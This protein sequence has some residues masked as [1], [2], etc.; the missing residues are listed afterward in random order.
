MSVVS[1]YIGDDMSSN[2]QSTTQQEP[3]DQ[4]VKLAKGTLNADIFEHF[5]PAINVQK[6]PEGQLTTEQVELFNSPDNKARFGIYSESAYSYTFT[7]PFGKNE[8]MHF[9]AGSVTLTSS[10]GSVT[11]INTGDSIMLPATW[12]GTWE[13]QGY[14]KIYMSATV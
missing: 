8:F 14:T 4:P 12:T 1:F 10:D 13:T 7:E 6:F 9:V 5:T 3:M 11:Q 2:N